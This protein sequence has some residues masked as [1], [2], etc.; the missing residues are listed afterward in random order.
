MPPEE[1]KE[2]NEK[3]GEKT[4]CSTS[5]QFERASLKE[6]LNRVVEESRIN[7]QMIYSLW[8]YGEHPK[9]YEVTTGH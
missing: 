7:N 8:A 9:T 1:M 6:R 5:N 2:L 4:T 3:N